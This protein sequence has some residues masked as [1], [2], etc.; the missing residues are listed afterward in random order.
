MVNSNK[1]FNFLVTGGGGFIGSHIVEELVS[2]NQYVR[3][4]DNFITGKKE[5]LEPFM[6]RIELFEYDLR[7]K[8]Q[9]DEV[10][11][12]IDY[13]IHQAALP[14]V[15]RSVSEPLKSNACNVTGTLNLLVASKDLG[16][17]RL[18]YASS[19]SVYG[20]T[21]VL[22]KVETM[23]TNPLSPYAVAKLASENYCKVFA[24]IFGLETVALR[25]FNVFGQRQ[26]PK[27][28]YAAVIPLFVN[29][30]LKGEEII[31]HG[32]GEQTRDFSYVKNVVQANLKACFSKKDVSGKAF[33]I[34]CGVRISLNELVEIIKNF[35]KKPVK[36]VNIDSRP[37]DVKHSL[38]DINQAK[39]L[40]DY[41]PEI[42][43]E[44]GLEI[45]IDWY[46]KQL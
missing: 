20:D 27:S 12:D 14:S 29:N 10:V 46:T 41:D 31:I 18:V 33:N 36:S 13:V 7:S 3:V 23:G 38:A 32:D 44:K 40:L 6:D 9:V 2:Q 22:P 4:I 43:V 19:S 26:D 17:K 42:S 35:T 11:K 25:Y 28:Q 5:N 24:S 37:G 15:P 34:A 45:Y 39:D 30:I 8:E 21:P 1:K 16:V